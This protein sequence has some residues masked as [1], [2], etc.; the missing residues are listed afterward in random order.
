M[1]TTLLA[2]AMGFLMLTGCQT[3]DVAS[4]DQDRVRTDYELFYDAGQ[5]KTTAVAVFR[6]G[7]SP[8]GTQLQ[9]SGPA[10]VRFNNDVLLFNSVL[11]RYEKT[12][13]G[14]TASGTFV[15]KNVDGK[16]FTNTTPALKAAEFPTDPAVLPLSKSQDYS[17]TWSGEALGQNDGVGALIL[18]T[19]VVVLETTP[20]TNR[21]IFRANALQP[22]TAGAYTVVMDRTV[23]ATLAQQSSAGGSIIAKHRSRSKNVQV[24]N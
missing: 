15:Y 1:K 6:F 21:L 5:N 8:T 19:A 4:V 16:T 14:L 7:N 20:G 22:V 17:V 24:S 12:Y 2:L 13:D 10:E 11:G 9:L 3:E 18:G 23:T